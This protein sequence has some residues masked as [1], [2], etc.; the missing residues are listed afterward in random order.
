MWNNVP[1]NGFPQLNGGGDSGDIS[2][3]KAA[4]EALETTVGDSE[5]GL[6]KD[7]ADIETTVGD[8]ESGLVKD[9]ADIETVV[10]DSESGLV[11]DITDLQNA[12]KYLTTETL[13]GKWGSS[14]LYRRY[15]T[16]SAFP[17]A[18]IKSFDIGITTET[19]RRIEIYLDSSSEFGAFPDNGGTASFNK[20]TKKLDVGTASDY[21][22]YTG[23]VIVE[24]TK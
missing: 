1:P 20:S 22:G 6:V 3:L 12:N 10:G 18:S 9:V 11:K 24:Y 7:V 4:V 5:S 13:V 23:V 8:S 2:E 19:V 16:T 21:S 15:V 14:N 17:N